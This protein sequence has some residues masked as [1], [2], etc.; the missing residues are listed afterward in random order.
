MSDTQNNIQEKRPLSTVVR[1]ITIL[2][3]KKTEKIMLKYIIM[4]QNSLGIINVRVK[5][6]VRYDKNDKQ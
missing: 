1:I 2:F 5:D 4:S 6:K 3:K